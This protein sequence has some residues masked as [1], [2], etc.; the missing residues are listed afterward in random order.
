MRNRSA[1]IGFSVFIAIV[2]FG[3][4]NTFKPSSSVDKLRILAVRAD[5]PD[6]HPGD[7]TVFTS[8]VVDPTAPSRVNTI[9]YLGCDPDP[10][11]L[12]QNP[13]SLY[14]SLSNPSTIIASASQ[15]DGGIPDGGIGDG[16]EILGIPGAK[17]LGV[18]Q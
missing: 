2:L 5:P 12:T 8:L 1:K 9:I 7:T 17:L 14:T 10:T 4:S 16:G 18:N 15:L 3:C 13:C 11:S 6:L